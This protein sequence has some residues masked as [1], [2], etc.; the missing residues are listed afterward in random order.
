MTEPRLS[1]MFGIFTRLAKDEPPPR[2]EQLT[3][4][5]PLAALIAAWRRPPRRDVGPGR[6][7]RRTMLFISQAG[8]RVHR[9][10]RADGPDCSR[11][12]P[13]WRRAAPG[14]CRSCF[15]PAVPGAGQWG[16]RRRKVVALEPA[17]VLP[18]TVS[19]YI[20]RNARCPVL[21]VPVRWYLRA[22]GQAH[23][24]GP[25]PTGS[26]C[27]GRRLRKPLTDL[28]QALAEDPVTAQRLAQLLSAAGVS[29]CAGRRRK[30]GLSLVQRR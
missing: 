18:G 16:R 17:H 13:V 21:V 5:G 19:Q 20:L 23:A 3:H 1:S 4:S 26:L 2:R 24:P 7:T 25:Q 12:G 28:G 11:A 6:R 29:R 9:A 27:H 22:E 15:A 14:C 8:H 10:G 30:R